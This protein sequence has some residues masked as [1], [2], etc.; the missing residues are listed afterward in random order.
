MKIKR[1]LCLV[2]WHS[3]KESDRIRHTAKETFSIGLLHGRD[4][5]QKKTSVFTPPTVTYY[6]TVRTY[7]CT[8]C[9]KTILVENDYAGKILSIKDSKD[10][11]ETMVCRP[12]QQSEYKKLV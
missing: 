4:F 2:G 6:D 1:L 8:D 12:G 10:V 9:G 3:W 11:Q 5:K 7:T